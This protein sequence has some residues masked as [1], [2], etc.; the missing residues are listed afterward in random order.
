MSDAIDGNLHSPPTD[1]RVMSGLLGR[2]W[3]GRIWV[4]QELALA[5]HISFACGYDMISDTGFKHFLEHWN[6]IMT[7]VVPMLLDHRPWALFEVRERLR[8]GEPLT[9]KDLLQISSKS[10]LEASDPRDQIFGL[11]S[12]AKDANALGLRVNYGQSRDSLYIDVAKYLLDENNLWMFSFC[13]F[14]PLAAHSLPSWVPDWSDQSG[15]ISLL[16]AGGGANTGEPLPFRASEGSKPVI[17]FT[18]QE[19]P[20]LAVS[21]I[22]VDRVSS[23]G[24]TRPLASQNNMDENMRLSI[25]SWARTQ[26]SELTR[27]KGIYG[28]EKQRE[29]AAWRTLIANQWQDPSSAECVQPRASKMRM[30]GY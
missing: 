19:P 10:Q 30:I 4:V 3:W 6:S 23:I 2:P 16:Q 21:G 1:L 9:L 5:K 28:T 12:L 29:E 11:F 25:L 20:L 13:R 26:F 18:D 22:Q 17:S 8:L 7:G 14:K 15:I 27:A 24:S